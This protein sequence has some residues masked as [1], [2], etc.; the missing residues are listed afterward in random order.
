[1]A[2]PRL[3]SN[4]LGFARWQ[5][6]YDSRQD[7]HGDGF[8]SVNLAA[9]RTGLKGSNDE[10]VRWNM[11]ALLLMSRAGLLNL[12][13]EPNSHG[14]LADDNTPASVLATL[15]I[16]RVRLLREDHMLS[17]AWEDAVSDSRKRTLE[18]GR[19]NLQL[20][21]QMLVGRREVSETLADLYRNRSP[22]WPIVVT[23]VMAD[24]RHTRLR[25]LSVRSSRRVP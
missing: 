17:D 8:F 20:I 7:D 1:M 2:T 23:R 12:E 19:R 18:A 15:A 25:R 22:Q 4:E 10:N 16:L 5:A 24:R 3:I 11:R 13:L 9:V 21:R 14:D 6:L